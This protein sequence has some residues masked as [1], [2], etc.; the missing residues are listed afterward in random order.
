MINIKGLS[1]K[2]VGNAFFSLYDISLNI[3]NGDIVGLIGT[4]GAGKTTLIKVI[5]GLLVPSFAQ[6]V[7]VDN[8]DQLIHNRKERPSIGLILNSN[9]LYDDLTVLENIKFYLLLNK[10]KRDKEKI[11][12][13]LKQVGLNNKENLLVKNCS[14]GM[15]QKVNIAKMILSEAKTLILD[16]PTS[17]MDPI[18][19]QE[20]LQLLRILNE[21]YGTTIIIS[22]H[23][24][25]DIEKI[26]NKLIFINSG[27]IIYYGEINNL[28]QSFSEYVYELL[29]DDTDFCKLQKELKNGKYKYYTDSIDNFNHIIFFDDV[30]ENTNIN[31]YNKIKKRKTNIE[32]IFFYI[33]QKGSS[34]DIPV[35]KKD[36]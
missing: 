7:L 8:Y 9:Q 25:S 24:I 19:K 31:I 3:N 28:V 5:S 34:N 4:N 1:H 32:D 11:L 29:L 22:S 15:K 10:K 13:T 30:L 27:Q 17:G 26:C 20:N 21:K 33:V 18:S 12:K 14:T 35:Y 36:I 6:M 16:E 23:I 2:Y